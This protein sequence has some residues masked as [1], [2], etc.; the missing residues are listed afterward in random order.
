MLF[1]KI[2]I[3]PDGPGIGPFA[4]TRERMLP[5]LEGRRTE[6][7]AMYDP[8]TGRPEVDPVALMAV[9][10]LQVMHRLPDRACADACRYD[11]R[12][13]FALGGAA[14]AFHHSTLS[15]FR[16]RLLGSGGAGAAL[17]AC[18]EAMRDAGYLKRGGAVRID[19]THL[20]ADIARMSRLECVRETL[21]LALL[22]LQEFGGPGAWEPWHTRYAER[23]P[24]ELRRAP[25]ALLASR[26]DAAGAD[27][28]GILARAGAL[29]P[30]VSAAE[31]VALLRRVFAEQFEEREGAPPAQRPAAP[32]GAAVNPRDPEAQW[33]TKGALGK[34]GWRGYKAQVCETVPD[35]VCAKGEP[36][37]AVITAVRVQP[38]T[39]SDHGSLPGTL[40]MHAAA[41]GGPPDEVNAD[42]GYVSAPALIEA[43]AQGYELVGP[44]PAPPHSG[45]RFGSDSF[46]VDIP[47]RA[48]RCPAGHASSEC[49]RIRDAKEGVRHYFAWPAA[50]CAA[51]NLRDRCL[52]KK[53]KAPRRTLDVG[54]HHMTV[55]DRRRLCRDDAYKQRLKR[56]AAI[57][58]THSGLVRGYGWRR[59]R[60]RGLART[61]LQGHLTA[62][63]CNLRRWAAR[64]CW[65]RRKKP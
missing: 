51:C 54:E 44:A 9:C 41:A 27:M 24:E 60:Y 43:A 11:A 34:D 46:D 45:A 14:P 38:A 7:E 64:L 32:A 47:G 49:S 31:P 4:L 17:D 65:E 10:V 21:R 61:Q 42:A 55:Q 3:D 19:S 53:K 35:A 30:A 22:F 6:L 52:S 33:S 2:G 28:R 36:T 50:L 48:A 40:A 8:R 59:C 56:R 13:A 25:A 57:E 58:G 20:L 18:L 1:I 29:G 23:N 39:A 5:A 15:N 37:T 26:M 62:A 63:A 12:W 16:A